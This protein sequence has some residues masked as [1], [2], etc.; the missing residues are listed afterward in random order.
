M[1]KYASNLFNVTKVSFFN[2]ID[3][4]CKAL[5]VRSEKVSKLMPLFALGLRD[6]LQE[7]GIYGGRAFGGMC[8]P[9]DL[10]AFIAFAKNQGIHVPLLEA[11]RQVNQTMSKEDQRIEV[12]VTNG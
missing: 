1:T 12:L 4:V 10:D 7:W 2:E 9:K 3:K 11:V 8:L 6:D 5:G